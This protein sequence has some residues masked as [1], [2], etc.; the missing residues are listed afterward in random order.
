MKNKWK[1]ENEYYKIRKKKNN[2][3]IYEKFKII[4][5]LNVENRKK[6]RKK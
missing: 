3:K 5:N 2:F 6:N 4:K 1:N